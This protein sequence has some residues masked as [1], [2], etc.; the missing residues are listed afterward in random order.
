M[1][2]EPRAHDTFVQS[3]DLPYLNSERSPLAYEHSNMTVD[4]GGLICDDIGT[5]TNNLR[6]T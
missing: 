3:L 5:P 4:F 6:G 2:L 1:L